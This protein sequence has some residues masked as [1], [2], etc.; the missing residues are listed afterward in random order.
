VMATWTLWIAAAET[1]LLSLIFSRPPITS[2]HPSTVL[3]VLWLGVVGSA[4]GYVLYFFIIQSW[5][6]SR[7]TL[8]TFVLPVVGL[9][10]G[11][12]FLGETLDWRILVGS[13]LVVLGVVLASLLK[14][15]A[16]RNHPAVQDR[17]E[18]LLS[19]ASPGSVQPPVSPHRER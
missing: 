3:A 16:R 13:A 7:A 6:A 4:L 17:Q 2:L 14:S 18:S 1:G 9:S 10:L 11:A 12:I 8:V 5:G 19:P 15:P